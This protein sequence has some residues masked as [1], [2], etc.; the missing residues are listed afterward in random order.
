MQSCGSGGKQKTKFW[1]M[2]NKRKI[3]GILIFISVLFSCFQKDGDNIE[4]C[5]EFIK[6][7]KNKKL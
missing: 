3:I 1:T 7:N 5:K 2:I 6:L 4:L